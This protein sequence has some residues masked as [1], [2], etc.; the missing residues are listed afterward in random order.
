MVKDFKLI[1][2]VNQKN[3]VFVNISYFLDKVVKFQGDIWN[4]CHDVLM[5]CMNFSN[6]VYL[7]IYGSDYCCIINRISQ[8]MPGK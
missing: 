8:M 6:I 7:I 1:R 3:V 2:K 4:G 5:M